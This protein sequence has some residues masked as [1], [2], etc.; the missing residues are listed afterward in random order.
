MQLELERSRLAVVELPL[1]VANL[2]ETI[3][4]A[5]RQRHRRKLP[6]SLATANAP[7]RSYG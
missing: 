2:D 6:H 7:L 5:P 1:R 4:L 3:R